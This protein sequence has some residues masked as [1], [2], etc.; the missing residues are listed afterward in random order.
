RDGRVRRFCSSIADA[1]WFDNFIIA[2]IAVSSA[3]MALD[4]PLHDPTSGLARFLDVTNT[5]F[6]FIFLVEMLIKWIAFGVVLN[7]GAY[8]RDSW[9]ILDGVVVIVSVVD[10]LPMLPDVSVLKTLRMLRALRPL[11]VISRN[12]NLRLVVNTLFR[13]L[14]ELCNL[15]IVGGLFFLIFGLFGLSYFKGKFYTCQ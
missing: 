10:L 6:T 7:K 1:P 9:N 13:I 11:R 2:C 5:L 15:L 14:P 8:W 12:P 3:L 4:S